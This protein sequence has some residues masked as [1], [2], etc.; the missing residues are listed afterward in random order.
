MKTCRD[1]DA[2]PKPDGAVRNHDHSL[3]A[4]PQGVTPAAS[5]PLDKQSRAQ[6]HA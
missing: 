2:D 5:N 3:R 1:Y 6:L 4:E